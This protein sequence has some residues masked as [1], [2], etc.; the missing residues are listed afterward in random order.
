MRQSTTP[1]PPLQG[2]GGSSSVNED[3]GHP[4]PL[5]SIEANAAE[6]TS[7]A[8]PRPPRPDP[9][10]VAAIPAELRER[11]Q[12]VVWRK[13]V[14]KG[15]LTKIPFRA[16][17]PKVEASSTD[18]ATFAE[19][20][21]AYNVFI[22]NDFI[23]QAGGPLDGI[24]FVFTPDDPYGG[25][26]LDHCIGP[27]GEIAGWAQDEMDRLPGMYWEISPSG[28]GVKGFG[29]FRLP[30]KGTR[31][32][33]VHG[34]DTAVEMYDQGRYFTATGRALGNVEVIGDCQESAE[35]LYTRLKPSK[36]K[37]PAEAR[38]VEPHDLDDEEL[39]AKARASNQGPKF[40]RVVDQGD[41]SGYPSQSEA[42]CAAVSL[43]AFW[44]GPDP[45]RIERIISKTPVGKRGKWAD[46][47]DYR[48]RTIAYV[49]ENLGTTYDPKRN[50]HAGGNGKPPLRVVGNGSEDPPED[51]PTEQKRPKIVV[52]VDQHRVIDEADAAL[53][54]DP[55]LFARGTML[56]RVVPFIGRR[57]R[58]DL[59]RIGG[60]PQIATVADATL[61]ERLTQLAE[62]V[63]PGKNRNGA[64]ID[65]PVSPPSYAV[66]GLLA[67]KAWTRV[68]H[69]EGVVEA[70]TLRPD[71]TVIET[72][73]WDEETGL[74]YA[75]NARFDPIPD[76]P[77]I[78]DARRAAR[79]LLDLVA[80]F[81]FVDDRHRAV[82]L[83]ALL[84]MAARFAVD[85]P[86]P[87]FLFDANTPGSGKSKLCDLIA[88]IVAGRMMARAGYPSTNEEME[89]VL[90]S[91]ALAGDRMMLFDNIAGGGTIGCASLDK[92]ITSGSINGRP[93]GRSEWV[94]LAW[95][96]V[97][98][99]TGNNIAMAADALR[100]VC[101]ARLESPD[102]R[103]EERRDF[104]IGKSCECGCEGDIVNHTRNARP[105]LLAAALTILRAHAIA[106]RP[107]PFDMP[108]VD[109][110]SWSKVI[111]AAVAWST[112]IDPC[113]TR[114][115][116]V[117]TDPAT[118]NVSPWWK[119]GKPSAAWKGGRT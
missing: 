83:A 118:P 105:A 110:Y 75:P 117:A 82:W 61:S 14:R 33:G 41:A 5:A 53:A 98:F 55:D 109:F 67:R 63:K 78:D 19:F 114:R 56:V 81:P 100:R 66:A 7:V 48:R 103:P 26:D 79:M 96:A 45:T 112:G 116:A 65:K 76:R 71:G 60:T 97:V 38:S 40:I 42:D 74:L 106:G 113:S 28:T 102:E 88:V 23:G 24:G 39:L 68:R 104:T 92:T 29:R 111:R 91:V 43:V 35:A 84:T 8:T 20:G 50:G 47:E 9:V 18:P 10:I 77:T 99:A 25:I 49:L 13:V 72:P 85:G 37:P 108:P 93:L 54:A 52:G 4:G 73:G 69:L 44:T 31:K 107:E 51:E 62:W 22:F 46:R 32:A 86:V 119:D 27:D 64:D 59:D 15:K 87:M 58:L 34:P 115:D 12:W 17:D 94:T 6:T 70:P 36:A 11:P 3:I 90:L 1:T 89:K 21:F 101:S 30:G 2:G 95:T 80:D 16:S 57:K